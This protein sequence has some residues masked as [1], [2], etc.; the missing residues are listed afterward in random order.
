MVSDLKNSN[1]G[2]WHSK[3]KRTSGQETGRAQNIPKVF[4]PERIKDLRNISGFFHFGFFFFD[5]IISEFIIEDMA[6][7]RDPAQYGNEKKASIQHYL[8]KMLHEILKTVDINYQSEKYAVVI[9]M[10]N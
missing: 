2:K 9:G 1:P 4:P 8:I 10:I 7:L 6:P 3:L 5:K